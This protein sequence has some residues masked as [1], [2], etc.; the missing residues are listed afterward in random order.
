[1][2]MKWA[3]TAILIGVLAGTGCLSPHLAHSTDPKGNKTPSSPGPAPAPPPVTPTQVKPD[4]AHAV[5]QALW[6]EMDRQA[7]DEL[8][9]ENVPP[10]GPHKK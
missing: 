4:N 5:S 6:D 2:N 1:M 8:L 10:S 9:V 7:Q 3:F